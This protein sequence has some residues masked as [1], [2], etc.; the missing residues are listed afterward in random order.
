METKSQSPYYDYDSVRTEIAQSHFLKQKL[1]GQRKHES[2]IDRRDALR[3][4]ATEFLNR[5]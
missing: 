5:S 2:D 1:D 3:Y 4:S